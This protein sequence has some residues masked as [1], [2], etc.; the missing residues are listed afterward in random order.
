MEKCTRRSAASFFLMASILASCFIGIADS[1]ISPA[2]HG[3]WDPNQH[4]QK[5]K[6][7]TEDSPTEARQENMAEPASNI[8]V[9]DIFRAEYR[10]WGARYGKRIDSSDVER[11]ENFKLVSPR[12]RSN[13]VVVFRAILSLA[14]KYSR[15]SEF[16]A[17]DAAQQEDRRLLPSKRIR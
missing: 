1:Y 6:A 13:G 8:Q 16:H 4:F 12:A 15:R 11:F 2:P 3:A 9:E 14:S 5:K 7:P 17:T 10:D